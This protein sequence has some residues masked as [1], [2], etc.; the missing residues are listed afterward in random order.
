MAAC[1]SSHSL[2]PT[3]TLEVP[4]KDILYPSSAVSFHDAPQVSLQLSHSYTTTHTR[5][6]I[7]YMRVHV[8]SILLA[9]HHVCIFVGVRSPDKVDDPVMAVQ[10]AWMM[11]VPQLYRQCYDKPL[12]LQPDATRYRDSSLIAAGYNTMGDLIQTSSVFKESRVYPRI[13]IYI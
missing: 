5:R 11:E 1:I 10:I 13:Y 3:H 7:L 12:Q 8:V 9:I 6:H 2:L 4:S